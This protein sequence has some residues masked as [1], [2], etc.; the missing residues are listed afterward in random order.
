MKK[1]KII[2][3][4]VSS[5]DLIGFERIYIGNDYCE[6]NLKSNEIIKL[7]EFYKNKKITLLLPFLTDIGLKKVILI[8]KTLDKYKLKSFEIVFND[9]GTFYYLRKNYPKMKLVLGRL[10]TKQR[11][12]PRMDIIL[13]NKQEHFKVFKNAVSSNIVQ[14]KKVPTSLLDLFSINMVETD[15]MI[16]FL[17]KNNVSRI[18]ID[19]LIWSMS[20][21]LSKKI[22]VSLY[23]PYVLLTLTRYCGAINNKYEKICNNDC[24]KQKKQISD[25]F[26][27]K[28]NALYY[29]NDVLPNKNIINLNNIDRLVYQI[30]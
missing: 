18:E 26:F 7:I 24:I 19:N 30:I 10:L 25:K 14:T 21:N 12:D 17:L 13:K 29:K 6:K 4:I 15:E 3:K 27:I 2:N 16:D 22:K 9:W 11:K 20:S 28:G 1:S 5:D 23:F 8:L